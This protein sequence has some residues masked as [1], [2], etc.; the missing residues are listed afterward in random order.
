MN[1]VCVWVYRYCE[2]ACEGLTWSYGVWVYRYCVW[3]THTEC[4]K[5]TRLYGVRVYR[6]CVC[7]GILI[8]WVCVWVTHT[9]NK[10]ISVYSCTPIYTTCIYICIHTYMY[11]YLHT[12]THSCAGVC[13][14]IYLY[15]YVQRTYIHTFINKQILSTPVDQRCFVRT[16]YSR[17]DRFSMGKM[18]KWEWRKIG[19]KNKKNLFLVGG[20][21]NS[22]SAQKCWSQYNCHS[23]TQ[24]HIHMLYSSR[25]RR[26][27][28]HCK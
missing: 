7:V 15:M 17:I 23:H 25:E 24:P 16:L 4:E 10:S 6:Y 5:L 3:V 2:C 11:E 22:K 26:R 27:R 12:Y 28:F 19:E 14:H 9:I 8:L 21:T 20:N 18:R 13:M 1:I